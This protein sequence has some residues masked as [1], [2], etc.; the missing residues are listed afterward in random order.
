MS[1]AAVAR[2]DFQDAA[3]S[4][5]LWGLT[6]LFVLFMAGMAY[7]FTLLGNSAGGQAPPEL[8]SVGLLV[9]LVSPVTLLIPITA[10]VIAHK[11]IAGEVES[12]SA[13]FLL[14]LPHTRRDAVVGK[15]VGRS[16]VMGVAVLVGLA[17]AAA[18]VLGLYD[19]FDA[20]AYAGFSVLAVLLAVLYTA[21]G[22]GLSAATN[23]SGRATILAVGFYVV[24]EVA[25]G[26]VSSGI[27][28]L[29]NGSFSPVGGATPPEWYLLLNRLPPTSAFSSAVFGFL[30]GD[31]GTVATLFP[32]NPPLYLS[33]WAAVATMLVWFVV[34]PAVG[35][36]RFQAA[37]L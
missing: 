31:L 11:A 21:I 23:D 34:V 12:G 32:Q 5:A 20:T 28:Y 19:S 17:V 4:K 1:W 30:P 9:F 7:V 26:L 8:E 10:L 27:Y 35:Y 2:K 13:K 22:V 16:A 33:K 36:W 15:V 24:F 14:S 3:R 29:L 37:D 18:V 25:W 6:A